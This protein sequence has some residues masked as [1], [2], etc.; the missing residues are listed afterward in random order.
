[1]FYDEA[2]QKIKD[3]HLKVKLVVRAKGGIR[4]QAVR[5]DGRPTTLRVDKNEFERPEE[6]ADA[7]VA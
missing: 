3:D 1:V 7:T 4:I 6:E 2:L 5:P